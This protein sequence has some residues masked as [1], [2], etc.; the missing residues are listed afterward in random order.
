MIKYSFH[1]VYVSVVWPDRSQTG[2][3]L[4]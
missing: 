3:K 2:E 1:Y 4:N